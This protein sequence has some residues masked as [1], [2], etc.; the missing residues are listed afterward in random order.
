MTL[1]DVRIASPCSAD[2]NAMP[3][4]DRVRTCGDCKKRVYNLVAMTRAEAEALI[5]SRER[6]CVRLYRRRD[7]SVVTADCAPPLRRIR[8]KVAAGA[9]AVLAGGCID[10]PADEPA[11]E[12]S[13]DDRTDLSDL[14]PPPSAARDGLRFERGSAWMGEVA[15]LRFELASDDDR[16]EDAA[17]ATP[18][19]AATSDEQRRIARMEA[20]LKAA[21]YEPTLGVRIEPP[22]ESESTGE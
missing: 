21:G 13:L 10:D 8:R 6:P 4:D 17:D 5:A 12:P 16:G 14:F 2:W 19:E 20:T 15:S 3:G 7:G 18:S 1:D 9:L 22:I 11:D